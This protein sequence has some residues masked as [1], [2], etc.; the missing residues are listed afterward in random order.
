MVIVTI[1]IEYVPPKAIFP[2]YI[3]CSVELWLFVKQHLLVVDA[4]DRAGFTSQG[5]E[6]EGGGNIYHFQHIYIL[7]MYLKM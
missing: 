4:T 7:K 5:A 3:C 6:A 2:S 1:E